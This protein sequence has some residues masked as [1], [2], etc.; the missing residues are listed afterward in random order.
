MQ[1]RYF[2]LFLFFRN[3]KSESMQYT[4]ITNQLIILF[5][6]WRALKFLRRCITSFALL[7]LDLQAMQPIQYARSENTAVSSK[8]K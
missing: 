6:K 8:F 1:I 4:W 2:V 3:F 7:M 5:S